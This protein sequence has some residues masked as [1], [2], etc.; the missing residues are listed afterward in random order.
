M[1]TKS[2]D[3]VNKHEASSLPSAS[4]SMAGDSCQMAC[5]NYADNRTA[6]CYVIALA[7]HGR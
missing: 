5:K 1:I 4:N 7:E 3:I 6:E 2:H